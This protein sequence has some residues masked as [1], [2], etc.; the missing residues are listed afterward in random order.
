MKCTLHRALGLLLILL[1]SVVVA[2]AQQLPENLRAYLMNSIRNSGH[3]PEDVRDVVISS[4]YTDPGTERSYAYLQQTW[5]GIPV[6]NAIAPVVTANGIA[7]GNK[8]PFVFNL[9]SK[10]NSTQP[11]LSP[12][13]A[14]QSALAHIEK[15]ANVSTPSP[16]SGKTNTYSVKI[17]SLLSTPSEI[18][19][20][21]V[22]SEKIARLA[23]NVTLDLMDGSHWWNIRIDALTGQ[24]IEKNDWVVS[25]TF[26]T[27][28]DH[29]V[30]SS[31]ALLMAPVPVP[32]SGTAQYNV[33]PLPLES[34]I[35][36]S[37]QL[38]NDPSEPLPSPYGWHD[39]N[40]AAGAEYNITRGNNV[41]AYE[42]ANNDNLPGFSPDG[43]STQLFNFPYS[44]D[45]STAYNQ[46]ASLTNLFYMNNVI[47][48]ILHPNGFNEVAGNFQQNNYGNGGL[49]A[50]YVNAEGLDGGGTNN[51]NFAT[52]NDGLNPRMQMYLWSGGSQTA[53]SN[54][55]INSPIAIAGAKSIAFATYNPAAAFNITANIVLANDGVGTTSDGCS[56]LTNAAAIAG[57][58]VLMDRGNCNFNVKTQN[59][60]LAGA[61]GVIIANNVT[62]STPP[63]MTGT[64]TI[65]ITI[66]TVS[67]TLADGNAIK[68]QLS[69][70]ATVNATLQVCLP[71]P[72]RDGGFDNGII[73]H[74]YGHGVSNR[75]TGG[76]AASSCLTNAEQGGEGWSDWLALITTIEPGDS[77]AMSRGIGTYALFQN[78]NGAGI[79]RYPYSTNMSINPQTY[80]D[81]ATSTT[82]HQRGEIWCDAIWDMTWF[83][84][85]DFGFDP[86]LYTGNSGNNI[87]LRLVLE[88]M[89]LQPCSPG[90][91]D[92]R[93]AILLAD[94]ILYGNAH[95]CQIWQAFARRG[96][97]FGASQG[98]SNA[99]G[100]ETVS[101]SIPAFCNAP[102][103]PPTADFNATQT[104]ASCPA[105]IQFN[106]AST[107]IPQNWFWNFGDGGTSTQ[108]NPMHTYAQPGQYSVKLKVTN[109]LGQDSIVK[110]NYIT[111]TSFNLIVTATPDTICQGDTIQLAAVPTASNAVAGYNLTTIPYAP[112]AGTGT[113]VSLADDAVSALLPI[114]F[115]FNFYGNLYTGFY[116]SS[117][118]FI[119]FNSTMT[120]GCCNGVAIPTPG[121][122]DNFIAF[123]WNDLNPSVNSSTITYFTTGAAP[124][125]QLVVKFATNHYN[126]TTYPMRG[127]IVL[128]E[129]TNVIEIHS[130]VIS[131]V[132]AVPP[133]VPE[134]PTTQGIENASGTA[135]VSPAGRS[136]AVFGVTNDAVRFTPYT[137]FGYTWTPSSQLSS[138]TIA[139][140]LAWPSSSLN[141][142]VTATDPNGC[143]VTQ[144]VPVVVNICVASALLNVKAYVEGFMNGSSTMQPVLYQNGMH[145]SP[146][147]SDTITI[148][149]HSATAPYSLQHAAQVLLDINGNAAASFPPA[150]AGNSY[151]IVVKTRNGIETW[152]KTPVLINAVTN[153]DFTAP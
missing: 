35:H 48:D 53:C 77:G 3:S 47:H 71:P 121:N 23:W 124:N 135:G 97:G 21:L 8:L 153:F 45:S 104:T 84:I 11:V 108:M 32:G 89:K 132:A 90:Y 145:V 87:A 81:L 66:P 146:A 15:T 144:S 43:G 112:V 42:D 55:N 26:D 95:R 147:A 4:Q 18:S 31:D 33:F 139:N 78:T 62:G 76:P 118:G 141:Y 46:S 94:D 51:A 131:A 38:L 116:I 79:R 40:G 57:K 149:L 7:Y 126:G 92:A 13:Q 125:R 74:E 70:P 113:A 1:T 110:T 120:H 88:G 150:T 133:S 52:P 64:P 130:E 17:P 44:I 115:T 12:A 117:N 58:I 138:S 143:A 2:P 142:L 63:A 73:A 114:G 111:I 123:A 98:S 122:P 68:G 37:R 39:T 10:V 22:A 152:S 119:G 67:I 127:Q 106:D 41:Y 96:M 103:L 128:Y 105:T 151:Y 59:A 6:F 136:A 102:A 80:A 85:R 28:H 109:T 30:H 129:T 107:N 24:F 91:I 140:P 14:V 9:A 19:L 16:V 54:L 60:Q 20:V 99:V 82:V 83:L 69:L 75:L 34:P 36:G 100:D 49:G 25:C 93:D 61:A 134:Q 72:N 5:K 101:F 56:A 86:N 50:D 65:T 27:P 148:E 137:V 29:A